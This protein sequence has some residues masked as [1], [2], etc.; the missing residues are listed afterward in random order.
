[1]DISYR[2]EIESSYMIIEGLGSFPEE[3]FVVK[4]LLSNSIKT[5]LKFNYESI[6]NRIQLMYDISEKQSFR[7][8]TEIRKMN[9]KNLQQFVFSLKALAAELEEYLL[10]ISGVIIK[11]ECIY[12]DPEGEKYYYC[13]CPYYEG[14]FREDLLELF[15]DLL[16][17]IDYSDE[18]VVKTAYALHHIVMGENFTI[19]ELIRLFEKNNRKKPRKIEMLEDDFEE[20]KEKENPERF[21]NEDFINPEDDLKTEDLTFFQKMSLYLKGKGLMDVLEDINNGELLEKI[22]NCGIPMD[23][24]R[25]RVEKPVNARPIR[26][27]ETRW[28]AEDPVS[29]GSS[30][31]TVLLGSAWDSVRCL[32][33]TGGQQG[34]IIRLE[35]YPFTI[36]KTNENTDS[37]I[38][39]PTVSRMHARIHFE[40][41]EEKY[42]IE[43]LNSK[44]GTFLNNES[45]EAYTKYLL[46]QGDVV[47]F[48]RE[49][50]CFK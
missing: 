33:G 8:L 22:N 9:Y 35:K 16:S 18:E 6:N 14:N 2:K 10:S 11:P 32:V 44:N 7:K 36:G 38:N 3:D 46:R 43:D 48:A 42:Y 13:Y 21:I 40:E 29:F 26:D 50:F 34:N 24:D 19:G 41:R 1:M 15:S 30:E 47:S 23:A 25:F 5:L 4:M 20:P 37:S 49:E 45:L 31:G 28:D 12:A 39:V 17:V 27:K